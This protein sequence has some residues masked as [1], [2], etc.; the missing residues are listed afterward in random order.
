MFLAEPVPGVADS[1]CKVHDLM[2]GTHY[3]ERFDEEKVILQA[4]L[5]NLNL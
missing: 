3:V 2:F 1:C 5:K 4:I